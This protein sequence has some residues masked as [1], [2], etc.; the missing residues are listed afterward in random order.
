MRYMAD[1]CCD[2]NKNNP[3]DHN[4]A[5]C[6][7]HAVGKGRKMQTKNDSCCNDKMEETSLNNITGVNQCCCSET[8]ETEES[9]SCCCNNEKETNENISTRKS[10]CCSNYADE[11]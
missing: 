11:M 7:Q 4:Q 8:N 1:K 2:S 3:V 6:D 10:S 9:V 5:C